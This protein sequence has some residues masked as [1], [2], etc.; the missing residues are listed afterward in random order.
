MIGE[1][2]DGGRR[3]RRVRMAAWGAAAGLVL[4]PLLA[5]RFTREVNWGAEDFALAAALV[6]GVG[7][8]FEIA[9][10]ATPSRA[11]RAGAG[12]ALATGFVLVWANAAVG[13]IGSEDNPANRMYAGVIAV[14]V[15]G[16]VLARFRPRGMARALAAT[17]AA[18][19]LVALVALLAG[20]GFAGAA[21][22]SFAGLWLASAWLFGRAARETEGAAP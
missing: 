20:W 13:I 18:Q 16:A 14:G 19:V 2:A 1:T 15:L 6:A 10:R 5:M 17:A 4:L 7:L 12:V 21:T 8:A 11:Y 22:V 9:V 3:G